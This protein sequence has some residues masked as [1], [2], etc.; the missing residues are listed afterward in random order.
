MRI[1]GQV[2]FYS[3]CVNVESRYKLLFQS[4]LP[5][6]DVIQIKVRLHWEVE[7]KR[8]EMGVNNIS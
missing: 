1:E 6:L 7:E 3:G 4:C 5:F 2:F 8:E